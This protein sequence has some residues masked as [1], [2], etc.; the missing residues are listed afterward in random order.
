VDEQEAR[1]MAF[2]PW[3]NGGAFP[4]FLSLVVRVLVIRLIA[5]GRD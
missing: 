1:R 2:R 5:V 3:K 4:T